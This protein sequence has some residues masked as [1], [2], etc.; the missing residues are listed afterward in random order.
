M[1]E[2]DELVRLSHFSR[3]ARAILQENSVSGILQRLMESIDEIFSAENSSVLL[4]DRK[5]DQLEFKVVG[6]RYNNVLPGR[7]IPA[8]EGIAG[9]VVA[10]GKELIIDDVQH[11]PRFSDRIDRISGFETKSIIAV[12]L[13]TAE[14]VFGV[15]ELINKTNHNDF[16]ALELHTL[17]TIADFAA[18]AIEKSVYLSRLKRLAMTD[19][20]TGLLNRR[21]LS[22]QLQREQARIERQGGQI[23]F[24]LADVD[25]FK[26]I[27]DSYGHGAGDAVLCKVAEV[28][29]TCSRGT[30]L[31]ARYGG[32]EFLV[33]M[34]DTDLEEAQ[35]LRSR[36]ESALGN[37]PIP[38]EDGM[39]G[40]SFGVHAGS[41]L[42]INV[43][44]EESDR[45]MYRRKEERL[46]QDFSQAVL[47]DYSSVVLE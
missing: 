40:V 13:K 39:F 46:E 44:L 35:K 38:N 4:L 14:R 18:I 11:D 36:L 15:V 3:F 41:D 24:I 20:L 16:S 26:L 2:L 8:F 27:N 43:L 25:N 7:R 33:V 19:P 22:R 10:F 1:P 32:D 12:P 9:W 28:L 6:G 34:P 42:D 31:L 23:A 47:D 29:N 37:T 30:E 5:N 21:G 17:A 45:D